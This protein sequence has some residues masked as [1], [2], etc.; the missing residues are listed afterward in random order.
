MVDH[1]K[2]VRSKRQAHGSELSG[3]APCDALRS[4]WLTRMWRY[5]TFSNA[6]RAQQSRFYDMIKVSIYSKPAPGS[7]FSGLSPGNG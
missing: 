5:G 7:V 3:D 6:V 2:L 4:A 1:S